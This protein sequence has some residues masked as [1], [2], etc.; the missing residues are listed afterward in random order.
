MTCPTAQTAANAA[1]ELASRRGATTGCGPFLIVSARKCV[2][3]RINK[4]MMGQYNH[5][6]AHG[7]MGRAANTTSIGQSIAAASQGGPS[8]ADRSLRD[9]TAGGISLSLSRSRGAE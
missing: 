1:R 8:R 6:D 5:A 2:E 9:A 7:W 4:E 3:Q